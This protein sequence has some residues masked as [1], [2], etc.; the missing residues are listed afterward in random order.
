M[1]ITE[2]RESG[3]IH[4]KELFSSK[5]TEKNKHQETTE[6]FVIFTDTHNC[7]SCREF[8]INSMYIEM[9]R[10]GENPPRMKQLFVVLLYFDFDF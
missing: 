9:N 7:Q 10:E 3:R 1:K 2:M 4:K 6:E 8:F 5:T